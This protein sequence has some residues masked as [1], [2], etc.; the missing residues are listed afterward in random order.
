MHSEFV[1]IMKSLHIITLM[2]ISTVVYCVDCVQRLCRYSDAMVSR[3]DIMLLSC[4]SHC[5]FV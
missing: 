5:T 2:I 4:S 3:I 1:S